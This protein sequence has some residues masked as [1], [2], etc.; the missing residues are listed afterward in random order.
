MSKSFSYLY[1]NTNGLNHVQ[2]DI[3]SFLY[4]PPDL[5]PSS[6][7][8]RFAALHS[9]D[10]EMTDANPV[11][12]PPRCADL[13]G[14]VECRT[15]PT[16]TSRARSWP[17]YRWHHFPQ[18]SRSGGL[19]FLIREDPSTIHQIRLDLSYNVR[20]AE[21]QCAATGDDAYD[22][23]VARNSAIVWLEAR[24]TN[25]PS[26]LYGLIYVH[27]SARASDWQQLRC[28]LDAAAS[29][30]KPIFLLGD[31]NIHEP[32][33]G[34]AHAHSSRLADCLDAVCDDFDWGV[35]NELH[36]FGVVT[37]P[38][39][40][41]NR[42]GPGHIIDLGLTSHDAWVTQFLVL[43]GQE[44]RPSSPL[45]SDH[46]PLL[47][48]VEPDASSF[49]PIIAVADADGCARPA[50]NL[51]NADWLEFAATVERF[52]L[53]PSSQAAIHPIKNC[54]ACIP[55]IAAP[56]CSCSAVLDSS[57]MLE[58]AWSVFHQAVLDAAQ[59]TFKIRRPSPFSKS[60]W[61]YPHG[62]LP[63]AYRAYRSALRKHVHKPLC[64]VLRKEL[65]MARRD[66]R[67]MQRCAREWAHAELCASIQSNPQQAI[68]WKA[69]KRATD[70]SGGMNASLFSIKHPMH[71]SL[72]NNPAES[73][74]NLADHY[75][76]VTQ[77]PAVPDSP[78][79]LSENDGVAPM[80]WRAAG[81]S[82]SDSEPVD[83]E[84]SKSSAEQR[85]SNSS[86][87]PADPLLA[88]SAHHR[89]VLKHLQHK[90]DEFRTSPGA[91]EL[92]SLFRLKSLTELLSNRRPTAAG[93][94]H[95]S[96]LFLRYGGATLQSI[97]LALFNYSWVHGTL[98]LDWRSAHVKPL[99]KPG[100]SDYTVADNLRPIA[101]TSCV[102][103]TMEAL[104][105]E[106]LSPYAESRGLLS[107]MQFGFRK[108]HSTHDA[109]FVLTE[110]IKE[111]LCDDGGGPVPV[112]FLDLAK[113]YDRTWH[114]GL[115]V[116]LAEVG[117]TGRMW[118]WIAAFLEGRRFRVVVADVCSEWHAIGASV[119]QGAVLSCLLFALYLD[120]IVRIASLPQFQ[121]P[122]IQFASP[123]APARVGVL[124]VLRIQ[125][126]ADDIAVMPDTRLV[127]WQDVFQ[128]GLDAMAAFAR[129]WR[130]TFSFGAG[131]STIVWF[132][133]KGAALIA[134]RTFYLGDQ[135][136]LQ[137]SQYKYLGVIL[138]AELTWS[139]HFERLLHSAR[140]AAMQACRM[141]PRLAAQAGKP[142]LKTGG[143]HFSAVR[144]IVMGAVY[145][146][147]TYGCMFISGP[148][149]EARM[150]SLQSTL[151]RP[152]RQFLGLP[153]TAHILS[154]FVE[155]DCPIPAVFREQL[156][157]GYVTRL[158]RM[159]DSGECRDHPAVLQLARSRWIQSCVERLPVPEFLGWSESPN[160]RPFIRELDAVA[161]GWG[162]NPLQLNA[163]PTAAHSPETLLSV[164]RTVRTANPAEGES[165][166]PVNHA[167][168]YGGGRPPLFAP[169]IM[170]AAS[171]APAP[172][173]S[174]AD[175]D[176]VPIPSD[177]SPPPKVPALKTLARRR[178]FDQ[179]KAQ[180]SGELL[181]RCKPNAGRSHYLYLE[182][183]DTVVLRA[184][185]RFNRASLR[186]SLAQRNLVGSSL[187]S[188]PAC[189][190]AR[191]PE[192]VEHALLVC[193]LLHTAR[194]ACQ[195][196]LNRLLAR[197]LDCPLPLETLLGLVGPKKPEAIAALPLDGSLSNPARRAVR[198]SLRSPPY[199]VML[200]EM[201]TRGS[202]ALSV[203]SAPSARKLESFREA[204]AIL[205]ITGAFLRKLRLAHAGVL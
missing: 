34:D 142:S 38:A 37:R 7:S 114:E 26:A 161:T 13:F 9:A 45:H 51:R 148:G 39:R 179:W 83:R 103:R 50:W 71:K 189:R 44:G 199:P 157:L 113:A 89:A 85:A 76:G 23:D 124:P 177:S 46:Y 72:P 169:R 90:A 109:V 65:A 40:S 196:T 151:V 178:T 132:R 105:H 116:R 192:S 190:A 69:W 145:S 82:E 17:G 122:F 144:A 27:P 59:L 155:C 139:A 41:R 25:Q 181:Q 188:Y 80:N 2:G 146:R 202:I 107:S 66:W 123:L 170:P 160:R 63:A 164:F 147:A 1:W 176:P 143:P 194:R 150:K 167:S 166:S 106:R 133:R 91:A 33:W 36:A 135:P 203:E 58:A 78:A 186:E 93:P 100:K 55:A 171:T 62:D 57:S 185:L 6:T 165:R 138:D 193:P 73:L 127:D 94:D 60:W 4:P 28:A 108:S 168:A 48:V 200:G 154:I 195:I 29:T 92:E 129:Q 152:L 121:R 182:P 120:P 136:L 111:Q 47:L 172:A 205:F 201:D 42:G 49:V 187:C 79:A 118:A 102:V 98:P 43:D 163:P 30:D 131:K 141:L 88:A 112:A 20:D 64:L 149:M 19:A 77:L 68:N 75:A 159:R 14:F 174:S 96:V 99:P 18:S 84:E 11:E 156:L 10:E 184:R 153:H 95:I 140:F 115:L 175:A 52:L 119:P 158:Q 130:F 22:H 197:P 56:V 70:H 183:R 137:E 12:Y 117:I 204:R 5:I 198:L 134:P 101:L 31:F 67:A 35:L 180:H 32:R 97:L 173:H 110:W 54:L 21:F 125:L 87:Q 128:Q 3:R 53:E 162:L 74:Q 16:I 191:L 8:N 24:K 86:P 81:G 126:F 15:S 61:S 104:I